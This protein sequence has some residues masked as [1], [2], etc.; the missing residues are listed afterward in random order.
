MLAVRDIGAI[1]SNLLTA[2]LVAVITSFLSVWL[3][4]RRFRAERLWERKADAYVR[5]IEALHHAKAFSEHHVGAD[6]IGR[7][8]SKDKDTELRN[9]ARL[10]SDEL[11]KA[12]DTA[13]LLLPKEAIVR[14]RQ[15]MKDEEAA[16]KHTSWVDYLDADAA[17]TRACLQDMIEIARLDLK[18]N[19]L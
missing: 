14:L 3:A 6:E 7:E 16:K 4:L 11:L 19:R 18:V 10:G 1:A 8:L 17:A 13:A 15:Y 12:I 9:R 2:I 5:I